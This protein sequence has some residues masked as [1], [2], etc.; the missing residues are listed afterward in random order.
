[1]GVMSKVL[2]KDREVHV[3]LEKN[4]AI[5]LESPLKFLGSLTILGL[6]ATQGPWLSASSTH[7]VG[8]SG[9]FGGDG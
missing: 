8:G 5:S 9:G 3:A 1:M 7:G 6:S 4:C 2:V